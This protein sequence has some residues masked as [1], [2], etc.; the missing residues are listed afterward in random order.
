MHQENFPVNGIIGIV[1]NSA[2]E[3]DEA[4]AARLSSVEI[5]ADLLL[6]NQVDTNGVLAIVRQAKSSG[7]AVLLTLRHPT[8]G[9]A[10]DGTEAERVAFNLA[11]L[12]AGADI[13]DAEVGTEA[14]AEL[15]RAGA[16]LLV[17]QHNFDG[18]YT[19]S[20]VSELTTRMSAPSANGHQPLGI[21]IVPTANTIGEAARM[22]QWVEARGN[23]EP[24]RIGFAMGAA[25]AASRILTIG[26]GAPITYAAFGEAVAPGQVPMHELIDIY[27]ADQL[28]AKT[29][30]YGIA[31]EHSLT[32]FSPFLHSP[33][34]AARGINAVYVPLQ[35]DDFDDLLE[36]A[37]VLRIDGMSVTT[38]FK[39]QA[40]A[41]A[42][43]S[44]D[45][46]QACGA[47][48]T[49][50]YERHEDARKIC[51][52]NTDFD[53]VIMPIAERARVSGLN[54]AIIG[55]GGA[56]RGAVQALK[57]AGAKITMF[58]RNAD[59]G[60]PVA[61]EFG[62]DGA[63]LDALD[64]SFD[65]YINATTLGTNEDDPSPLP[66]SLLKRPEQIAFEMLYQ[67]PNSRLVQDAAER[68][69][70]IVRGSE[71]LVAQGTVQFDHFVGVLP[72]LE[73]FSENFERGKTYRF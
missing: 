39:E 71:M 38:P 25:G 72:S 59:R 22:L 6:S 29:R 26:Y 57:E 36:T 13:V 24:A 9:G 51:A 20:E 49:L 62:V 40:L 8:H 19:E 70:Q 32:S 66:K 56:A 31:G 3:V 69:V 1:A 47:S 12:E 34:F 41:A 17:S 58:Y 53:G 18:M 65:V 15:L 33:A 14:A 7:L 23:G 63:L 11:A 28:N 46:S 55:N 52:Y 21:K 68:G 35:T 37:D 60:A 67:N 10:F 5:R 4:I 30:V 73:E 45:R 64:D 16:P 43:E 27:R 61:A 54:I 42:D 50:V 44:D 48:N 2:A